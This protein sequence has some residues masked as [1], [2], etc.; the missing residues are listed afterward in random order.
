MNN[1]MKQSN[2]NNL[3]ESRHTLPGVQNPG[4]GHLPDTVNPTAKH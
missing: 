2:E 1:S 4:T 3:K